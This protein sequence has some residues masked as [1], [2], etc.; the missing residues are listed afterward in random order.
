MVN[1]DLTSIIN[2]AL[3]TIIELIKSRRA[4]VDP[5]APPL[6]DEQVFAALH[7]AVVASVAKDDAIAA[8]IRARNPGV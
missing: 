5:S 4:T 6:T 2:T 8:D 3:P 7:D 1:I